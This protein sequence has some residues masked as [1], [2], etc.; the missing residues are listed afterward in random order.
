MKNLLIEVG[1]P[2]ESEINL[3]CDNRAA[4]QIA[5][6]PVQHYQTKYIEIDRHFIKE[7]LKGKIIKFSFVKS[8]DQLVDVLTKAVSSRVFHDL[9]SKLGISDIY[10][11][12]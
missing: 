12:T 9:L 6:N 3:Y 7:K 5:H 1:Y 10:A 4:I 8:E 11:P 2:S